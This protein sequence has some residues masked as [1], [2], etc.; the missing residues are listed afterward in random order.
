MKKVLIISSYAPPAIG[1][2]QNLYNLFRDLPKDSYYVLTSFY[3]IDNDSAKKGA[4]LSGEYF[5]YDNFKKTAADLKA[6]AQKQDVI[7]RRSWVSKIKHL[8]K[9]S[10]ILWV[11]MGPFIIF[12]QILLITISAIK[13]FKKRQIDEI[14]VFSDYGPALIGTYIVHLITKKAYSIFLF[15][16]YK[17]NFFPFPGNFLANL[18]EKRI[19]A[20]ARKIIVTNDGTK[21]FY[22][23]RY[24]KN[25][26]DKIIIIYNAVFPE[27][28]LALKKD[29]SRKNKPYFDIVF[30]GRIYWP[31]IEAL[32][33]LMKAVDSI[34]DIDIKV[35]IYCPNPPEYVQ[36]LGIKSEKA[37][38]DSALP[39]EMPII[40]SQAD[41]LFLP[42]SWGTK[43]QAII[44]TATPSKLTDYLI[45]RRPILIHAP[46]SSF[47]VKYAKENNFALVVD[48]NNIEKLKA[49]I[50]KLLTD[51]KL[52]EKLVKNAQKTFFKNHD[53]KKNFEI[54]RSLFSKTN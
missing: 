6:D 24:G 38:F 47:L 53:P 5:F 28:Y 15:D 25:I 8:V 29:S 33:N 18:F 20:G 39:Q 23:K 3:N 31:Q 34:N 30:T 11:A 43:S 4:W 1:G 51:K 16:L 26:T 40:Q 17:G 13:V 2:P 42:L 9:R 52:S 37:V 46:A 22:E 49:A 7:K 45:A 14:L 36:K 50:K 10:K 35:K 54:F 44:D 12:G 21:N 27:P 19:F 41:I 48:E 32:K